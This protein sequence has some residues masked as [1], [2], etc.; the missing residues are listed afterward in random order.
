[1]DAKP[2][3]EGDI[4][5]INESWAFKLKLLKEKFSHLAEADLKFDPSRDSSII[6]AAESQTKKLKE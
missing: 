2:N 6:R 1:M 3:T 4:S 5:K